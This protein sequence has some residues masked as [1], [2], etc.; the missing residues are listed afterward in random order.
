MIIWLHVKSMCDKISL[1]KETKTT[2]L[3][4]AIE[5]ATTDVPHSKGGLCSVIALVIYIIFLQKDMLVFI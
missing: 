5:A 4:L 2:F 3:P 1:T